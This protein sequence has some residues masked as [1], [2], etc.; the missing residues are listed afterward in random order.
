ML[1]PFIIS[2]GYG[3]YTRA[4]F[5]RHRSSRDSH[6]TC[7]G[8]DDFTIPDKPPSPSGCGFLELSRQSVELR[9]THL[10]QQLMSV[11]VRVATPTGISLA[12]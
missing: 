11:L 4:F 10:L 5:P 3:F 1:T 12:S 9:P 2:L 6:G 7:L 8:F